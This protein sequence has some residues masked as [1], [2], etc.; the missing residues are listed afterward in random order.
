[1]ESRPFYAG[2]EFCQ[3]REGGAA[4]ANSRDADR[5]PSEL[6]APLALISPPRLRHRAARNH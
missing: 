2:R 4:R 3:R 5:S 6:V 1:M